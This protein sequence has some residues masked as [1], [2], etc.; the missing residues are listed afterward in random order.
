M[1]ITVESRIT[2]RSL[3]RK[4]KNELARIALA[5][6]DL[7]AIVVRYRNYHDGVCIIES[8][9]QIDKCECAVCMDAERLLK[10][11]YV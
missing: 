11:F 10:D 5:G 8:K 9:E 3:M 6:I 2:H 4:S 1:I 7:Q